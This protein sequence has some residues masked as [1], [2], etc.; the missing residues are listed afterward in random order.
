MDI[1]QLE[2]FI[3]IVNTGSI[4]GAARNMFISQPTI[5]HRLKTL[6]KEIG[7]DLIERTPGVRDIRLTQSG[8]QFISIAYQ[9]IDMWKSLEMLNDV[10]HTLPVSLG[11]AESVNI[12]LFSELYKPLIRGDK[13]PVF[14]LSIITERSREIHKMIE[15]RDLD[16]GFVY[17]LHPSSNVLITP[18]FS[19]QMLVVK[20][21]GRK[22][23][24]RTLFHTNELN[25]QHEIYTR[26]SNEYDMW[27][28]NMWPASALPFITLDSE[29]LICDYLDDPDLWAIVPRSVASHLQKT[30]PGL[31][32][33]EI[34]GKP[35]ERVCYK[36]V[37][38][39]PN[40]S[41][42]S[43]IDLFSTFLTGFINAH[44]YFNP[45]GPLE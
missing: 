14:N 40:V 30:S 29:Y 43:S 35:P 2:T 8:K 45:V 5:S 22:D 7:M 27:H 9:L 37:H 25:P 26:W 36:I 42:S 24:G 17:S 6:E 18:L 4:S 16:I 21:P 39:H 31:C 19:E 34:S 32:I 10:Q 33:Y 28:Q 15:N 12:Q 11:W 3:N 44:P 23:S 1:Q 13:G 38:R 41:R 20:H